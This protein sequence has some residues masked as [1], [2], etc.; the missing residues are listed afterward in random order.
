MDQGTLKGPDVPVRWHARCHQAVHR[1]PSR[2][3]DVTGRRRRC[4][5]AQVSSCQACAS[6]AHRP[7]HRCSCC[8]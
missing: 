7:T 4:Q 8:S 5:V 6:P 1:M 3:L 2:A